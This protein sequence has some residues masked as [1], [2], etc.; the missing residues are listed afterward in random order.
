MLA[1]LAPT[2]GAAQPPAEDAPAALPATAEPAMANAFEF[3]PEINAMKFALRRDQFDG[4]LMR[5]FRAGMTSQFSYLFGLPR[6]TGV[7]T[8]PAGDLTI[9]VS[10]LGASYNV[11]RAGVRSDGA[12]SKF[13]V[14]AL[15]GFPLGL[16]LGFRLPVVWR[17]GDDDVNNTKKDRGIGVG[18]PTVEARWNFIDTAGKHGL[19]GAT[20]WLAFKIPNETDKLTGTGYVDVAASFTVGFGG[21]RW[22]LALSAG[23]SGLGQYDGDDQKVFFNNSEAE[24][25]WLVGATFGFQL[26]NFGE[27][28][29]MALVGQWQSYG[30]AVAPVFES[31]ATPMHDFMAGIRIRDDVFEWTGAVGMTV[32]AP[33]VDVFAYIA[34]NFYLAGLVDF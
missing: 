17:A 16:E 20:V 31:L 10:A 1:L 25:V 14:S 8:T 29:D 26:A 21:P 13:D 23:Y 7:K 6:M 34:L 3:D 19:R 30:S 22:E 4:R 27:S 9:G 15:F 5:P 32:S 18:E 28:K 2:I 24:N 33:G 11:E 12:V